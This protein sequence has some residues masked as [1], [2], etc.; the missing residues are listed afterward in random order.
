MYE[1]M[2]NTMYKGESKLADRFRKR[3]DALVGRR[4][5][6]CKLWPFVR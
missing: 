5:P 3:V 1:A 4:L 6:C 2:R